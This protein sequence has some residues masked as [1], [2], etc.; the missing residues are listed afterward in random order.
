MTGPADLDY[1]A[2]RW[3]KNDAGWHKSSSDPKDELTAAYDSFVKEK[4]TG[5]TFVPLCGKTGDLLW[6]TKEKGHTV[7]GVEGVESVVKEFFAENSIECDRS[8]LDGGIGAKFVS[9]DGA[10]TV[11][12]CDI[13]AVTPEMVGPFDYVY[14][15]GGLVALPAE[16]RPR[17]VKVVASL[18]KDRP[19]R[20]LLFAYDYDQTKYP[21]P[22][23][24]VPEK[25]V[26]GLYDG[27]AQLESIKHIDESEKGKI[28]FGVETMTR[29]Q[30]ILTAK[31]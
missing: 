27:F 3:N 8:E 2:N 22:P 14:D 31:N 24:S 13:M 11:L 5:R 28:R 29:L 9:K 15:R 16:V 20:Y 10:I 1:W 6:L 19:F 25:E 12:A 17:Y 18:L 4:D 30:I 7:I 23:H 26:R 21:G